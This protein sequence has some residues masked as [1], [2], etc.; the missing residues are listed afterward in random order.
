MLVVGQGMTLRANLTMIDPE[1]IYSAGMSRH[2]R[3][4]LG[5]LL[6]NGISAVGGSVAL[7]TG[8]IPRQEAWLQHTISIV[9]I[10]QA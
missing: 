1:P 9:S 10:S 2:G 5:L 3:T 4:V 8:V 7:M 6:C